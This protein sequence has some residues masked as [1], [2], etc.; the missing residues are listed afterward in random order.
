[1]LYSQY[2]RWCIPNCAAPQ[3][4]F[5]ES[6]S[7]TVLPH[8][9]METNGFRGGSTTASETSEK[10]HKRFSRKKRI[11]GESYRRLKS[12]LLYLCELA[13][14]NSLVCRFLKNLKKKNAFKETRQ[15]ASEKEE[16]AALEEC[17][18][19]PDNKVSAKGLRELDSA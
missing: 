8:W 9:R 19:S 14:I 13:L 10:L 1:M 17:S 3:P 15:A 5:V 2:T 7:V 11:P 18:T 16:R 6:V 4:Q 12:L